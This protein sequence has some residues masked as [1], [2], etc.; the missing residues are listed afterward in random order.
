V[1]AVSEQ[2]GAIEIVEP[3]RAERAVI[4]RSAEARATVPDLELSV[5]V[6]PARLPDTVEGLEA[7]V[8]GAVARTLREH[9]RLNGAYRDGHY[10]LHGRVNVGVVLGEQASY[11]VATVFDADRLEPEAIAAELARLRARAAAGEL[12]P[13][14]LSGATFSFWFA[15]DA[16]IDRAVLPVIPPHAAALVAG[17]RRAVPL[18][19]N[20]DIV[21][22][23]IMTLT[24]ACDHRIAFGPHATGFLAAVKARLEEQGR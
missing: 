23:E 22:G 17:A 5:D 10:E 14:E 15:G 1:T 8:L 16:G 20:G 2:K 9:R 19:R 11:P 6:E 13:P 7:A 3:S 12:S 18:I 4:R 21:P 24:L